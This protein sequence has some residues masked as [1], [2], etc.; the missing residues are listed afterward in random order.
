MSEENVIFGAHSTQALR[1]L[2]YR[3][4][5]R[6]VQHG[7]H[8]EPRDPKPHQPVTL[9]VWTGPDVDLHSLAV[10]YT[11]DGSHPSSGAGTLPL[12]QVAVEWDPL[13]WGYRRR[14]EGVIPG[15]PAG[16]TVHYHICGVGVEHEGICADWPPPEEL[17][18]AETRRHFGDENAVAALPAPDRRELFTYVVDTL[19]PPAWTREAVVYQIFVDRFSPGR[20]RI[21]GD[22]EDLMGFFGGTL[23]GVIEA[24]HYVADLGANTLWLSPIFP[25]PT[26]HG[27]DATDY[28][29]V[30]PRLGTLDDFK[31]LVEEVHRRGMRLLL[32]LALN[33]ASNEHPLYQKALADPQ[34]EYGDWFR[35]DSEQGEYRGYFGL[36]TMPEWNTENPEVRA[37]FQKVGRFWLEQGA[38]GFRLDYADGPG[39]GF[40]SEFRAAC[41]AV[42]PEA[43]IFGEVVQPP[44]VLAPYVGRLDGSLDFLWQQMVR[45]AVA[46]GNGGAAELARFLDAHRSALSSNFVRPVFLDNHDIDRF[47]LAAGNDERRLRL[48]L[49]LLLTWPQPPILFYGT[50]TALR[51]PHS[52]RDPGMGLEASRV[53]MDWAAARADLPLVEDVQRLVG[54]RATYPDLVY[55]EHATLDFTADYWLFQ[56]RGVQGDFFVALNLGEEEVALTLPPRVRSL[57]SAGEVDL[58]PD[59]STLGP[60]AGV[61]LVAGR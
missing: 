50:E 30:E 23:R 8:I 29:D 35:F 43:W 33:H 20:G 10:H 59:S 15:Q 27:Y 31:E 3:E 14:W 51:Q 4:R 22:P 38:D 47:L 45:R 42:N 60:L 53:P 44:D 1:L 25:S 16:T 48:G 56:R 52:S 57:W 32:D 24:L 13:I 11:T 12:R 40:W 41:R 5:R 61:I 9:V 49:L 21:L 26:H 36:P 18:L 39:P 34:G 37:Y 28:F 46:H 7:S 2:N 17:I 19:A 55:G 58:A 6:G 54:L